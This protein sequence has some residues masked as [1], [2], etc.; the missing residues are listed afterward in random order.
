MNGIIK[1]A[2]R[3]AYSIDRRNIL[4]CNMTEE[5]RELYYQVNQWQHSK[6][7]EA[8]RG[9]IVTRTLSNGT[10]VQ[11][12]KACGAG[13]GVYRRHGEGTCPKCDPEGV[14]ANQARWRER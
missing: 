13:I 14:A 2:V 7:V 6:T 12:C 5:E 1:A 4:L 10:E 3:W 11:F 8:A 9:G